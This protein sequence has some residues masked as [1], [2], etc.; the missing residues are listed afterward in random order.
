MKIIGLW[1]IR[2][3]Q[4]C[5]SPLL[6]PACKYHPTC[7][8][9]AYQSIDRHGFITGVVM[10]SFRLCRCNPWS[11]GGADPVPEKIRWTWRGPVREGPPP[12][13]DFG[14]QECA[15]LLARTGAKTAPLPPSIPCPAGGSPPAAGSHPVE[16]RTHPRTAP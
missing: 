16:P 4:R 10:G 12:P 5:L 11:H 7:S 3:Y 8:H 9:Y 13:I 15:A 14:R 2:A 6:P 1:M